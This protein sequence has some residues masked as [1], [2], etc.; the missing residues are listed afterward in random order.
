MTK[1]LFN[2]ITLLFLFSFVIG[3]RAQQT[4]T[5]YEG[6]AYRSCVPVN[7]SAGSY[8][9]LKSLYVIPAADLYSMVNGSFYCITYHARVTNKNDLPYTTEKDVSIYIK[10][11]SY[12]EISDFETF[13]D[14]D[15]VYKGKLTV[16]KVDESN[17]LL[18]ITL[19]KPYVYK[20][21]NLLIASETSE[22]IGYKGI[23]FF[24]KTTSKNTN[25]SGQ[26]GIIESVSATAGQFIPRTTFSY[27]AAPTIS[28][29]ATTPTTSS[30]SWTGD[31][32]K[33]NLRYTQLEFFDDFEE[34]LD[35][36]TVIR[37]GEGNENTDWRQYRG[38][39]D[40]KVEPHSGL[41]T[42]LS[43]SWAQAPYKVDN[44][45]ISPKVKLEGTLKYWVKD[46]GKWHEHYDV[47]VSTTDTEL[48]SF[49]LFATPGN[50]TSAW[51]EV[52][53]DLSKFDG[54]EGYI[55]FR[56][57]DYDQDYLQI[58]DIGIFPSDDSWK[59]VADATSP[60]TLENLNEDAAY[61][62]QV[63]GLFE[64]TYTTPW[65]GQCF[66]THCNP[67]PADA[68]VTPTAYTASMMWSGYGD[69]Y[70]LDYRTSAYN[71]VSFSENFDNNLDAWTVQDCHEGTG[72]NGN[73]AARRSGRGG[74]AFHYSTTP[75]QY[76]I[77]NEISDIPEGSKLLFY[78][79]NYHTGYKESFLVG[80][81]STTNDIDAFEFGDTISIQN[82]NWTAFNQDVPAGTKYICIQ[83]TSDDKAYLFIDDLF[84][85]KPIPEGEWNTITGITDPAV[86]LTGLAAEKKYDYRIRSISSK[87]SQ[88]ASVWTD[89]ASFTTDKEQ[90][91]SNLFT[92]ENEWAT[93]VPALDV[94]I[95]NGL[96]AY[97]INSLGATTA[98]A[99]PID[100]LPKGMP[101]LIKRA[102]TAVNTYATDVC[103][104]TEPTGNLLMIA[105]E[106]NQPEALND[107][108][109]YN[110]QFVLVSSGTLSEGYVYLNVP[111]FHQSRAAT[112][113]IVIGGSDGSTQIVDVQVQ[114]QQQPDTW[115][116]LSGRKVAAP[117]RKGIYINNG[118]KVVVR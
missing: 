47:Y 67:V 25:V 109:L 105:N 53:I 93:Y 72:L 76:L 60:Y 89:I 34:G 56:N 98:C 65:I 118:K 39:F 5:V 100:Y 114:T 3:V 23:G 61:A 18:N 91:L 24:G 35:N 84:I 106:D 42:L 86:T 104:G 62:F 78:Y 8:K 48:S 51:T 99:E 87:K 13:T 44:W 2:L 11:V 45:I 115:F 96:T 52:S 66:I 7:I 69:S 29:V 30:V 108:V 81:S 38:T 88:S 111:K 40:D 16:E 14:D 74:F 10:E 26:A 85:Y 77:S 32:E 55:A 73:E 12:N 92:G 59:T 112:R 113:S 102:D 83:C 27:Y 79:K 37:N 22:K 49:E 41:H 28:G 20:G 95:P 6:T 75:P 80:Y 58:D 97:I 21:G 4:L 90:I 117:N 50:A 54:K 15:L 17:G 19:E 68:A 71:I 82:N 33:Y 9:F 110:D 36:W 1:R 70:E 43:R 64:K 31:T 63:C 101:V 46:D 107:F 94:A 103:T 57:T 116:Y